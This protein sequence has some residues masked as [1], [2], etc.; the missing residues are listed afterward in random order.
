MLQ[1][2]RQELVDIIAGLGYK[3][4]SADIVIPPQEE[5][6]D[7]ALPCF[8]FARTMGKSPV[9]IAR[10]LAEKLS[11]KLPQIVKSVRSS[12]PYVNFDFDTS[13]YIKSVISGVLKAKKNYGKS[14][15]GKGKKLVIEYPSQNTHKE[16]HV[17]HVRN[18]CVGNTL[19]NLYRRA[20]YDVFV[21]N[22]VN[23]FGAHVVKCLWGMKKFHKGEVPPANAQKWLGE[24]YAE[25][26]RYIK[27]NE[28]EVKPELDE[29]L[30]K[31]EARDPELMK[32]FTETKAWSVSGFAKIAAELN[33]QHSDI[34][35]ES[36]VKDEGQ[37]MVDDLLKRGIAKVGEG[38][39]IIVDLSEY[40]LGIALIR[41]SS[42]AGL[43][44]TSD[45]ALARRKFDKYAPDES[46][47]I[48]GL[49]QDYYF[50]QLF[51]IL[52]LWGFQG[53][54]THLSSG[55]VSRPEGKMS[56]RLGNVI[57]YDDLRD[58]VNSRLV[59]ETKTR[60]AD[61]SDDK[62]NNN[63]KV[64]TQA[65]LKFSMLKHEIS[66]N[67]IFDLKEAV[68]F[69]GFSAPYILYAVAR[70]KNL[71]RKAGLTKKIFPHYGSLTNGAEKKLATMIALWS[72]VEKDSF[73]GYNPSA[74]TRYVFDL[75][76]TVSEF[77]NNCPILKAEVR[78]VGAARL[79]LAEAAEI[80]L[81]TALGVLSI[82]TV[83]E[84]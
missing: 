46:I 18:A 35:Y 71:K 10:E 30:K 36:E 40:D 77:Y 3:I 79:K 82:G 53:K 13:Q 43:Y 5:M 57:L 72:E 76:Q 74:I 78:G 1:S 16:F 14:N 61:W 50:K 65:V 28:A 83:E 17:G 11:T 73:A 12:G 44:I 4:Q 55:L 19:V 26:S 42:G 23:D 63:A 60:H 22:Y 49:E 59:A 64:L 31:L 9:E 39:A 32:L 47:N 8:S 80:V 15:S 48:T 6:G 27:E 58:E 52:E 51:K 68:S 56:S 54:M 41:K 69:E 21:M 33:I 70:L 38:G 67:F 45:L 20:G 66:K 25:A 81:E 75:A 7:L 24:I 2:I 29:M 62:I 34:I 84:M 37:K